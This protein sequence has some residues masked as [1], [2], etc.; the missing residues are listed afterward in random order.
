MTCIFKEKKKLPPNRRTKILGSS[1][2]SEE[3]RNPQEL[4]RNYQLCLLRAEAQRLVLKA[5]G[6][7]FTSAVR[8]EPPDLK[9]AAC[10]WNHFPALIGNSVLPRHQISAP[11]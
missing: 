6:R 8:V 2:P 10:V 11:V 5:P 7:T 1:E 4:V 3:E 9:G